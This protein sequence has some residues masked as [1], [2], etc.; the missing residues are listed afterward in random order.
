MI[1]SELNYLGAVDQETQVVGAGLVDRVDFAKK[2]KVNK[3]IFV[4]IN[5][6]VF[7]YAK[8]IGN[9]AEAEAAANAYGYDSLAET[10]TATV[11]DDYSSHA[12]SESTSASDGGY[13]YYDY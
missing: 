11:S 4:N 3:D 6:Y 10:L 5:K 8:P 1:I 13:Y 2:V 9:L 12:L 7:S